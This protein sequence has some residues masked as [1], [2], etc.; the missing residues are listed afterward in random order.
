MTYERVTTFHLRP[1]NRDR[2]AEMANEADRE[3]RRLPGFQ[4]IT[5][6]LDS[7]NGEFCAVSLWDSREHAEQV[8]QAVR[9]VAQ[10]SVQD[11][12]VEPP[13]THIY[14]VYQPQM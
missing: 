13:S 2:I 14:E 3:I 7:D 9:D 8:T 10:R 11:I 5:Y 6:G 12:L 1:G 4:S